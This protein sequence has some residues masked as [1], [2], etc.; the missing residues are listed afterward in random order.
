MD[1]DPKWLRESEPLLRNTGASAGLETARLFKIE[2]VF[3]Q[4]ADLPFKAASGR[5]VPAEATGEPEPSTALSM[6]PVSWRRA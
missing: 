3:E 2:V 5:A 6:H 4:L 1:V